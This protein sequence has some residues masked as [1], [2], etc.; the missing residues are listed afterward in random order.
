[1]R[2]CLC[3]TIACYLFR[4]RL[5]YKG[6][7]FMEIDAVLEVEAGDPQI[8]I[9]FLVAN[10]NLSKSRLKELMNKGGVWRISLDG[11]RE[12]L[13]R[14]MTDIFV[15]EQ[16]EI[17][18]DESL[19]HTKPMHAELLSDMG[20][21]SVW[22]K[23]TGM[24]LFGNDFG[25]ANTFSREA[26]HKLNPARE[27]LWLSSFDYE[28][29]GLVIVAHSRKAAAELTEQFHPSGFDGEPLHYRVEL[30]GD[31]NQNGELST[32]LDDSPARMRIEKVRYDVRPNRTIADVWPSTG[33]PSQIR[34]HFAELGYPLVG[35]E[36]FGVKVENHDSLRLKL[37]ELSFT[38]PMSGEQQHFSLVP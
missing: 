7:L 14:A 12:R 6:T 11:E 2:F 9:D 26:N 30:I 22:Q 20:Q 23:P 21:Y 25:D 37:V 36:I 35:D 28:A 29:S 31:L 3:H 32:V 34:R 13:R 18:Y 16:I 4:S 27:L 17:F 19:F 8:A 5:V 33:Q 15:G 38:C 24:A 1:M 10:I